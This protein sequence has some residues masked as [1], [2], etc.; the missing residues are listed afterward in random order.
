MKQTVYVFLFFMYEE[1]EDTHLP[2]ISIRKR[3]TV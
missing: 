3:K 1:K 2:F